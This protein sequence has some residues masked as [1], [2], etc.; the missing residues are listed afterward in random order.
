MSSA[1][2]IAALGFL[3]ALLSCLDKLLALK[4]RL[5]KKTHSASKVV[6]HV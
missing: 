3:T 6:Q 4:D 5:L 2:L 1:H